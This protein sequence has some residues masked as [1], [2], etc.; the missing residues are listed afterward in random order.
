MSNT[1]DANSKKIAAGICAILL[2][3]LGIHK[4]I[5]G[6]TTQGVI[7]L[8]ATLLTCGIGGVVT[9]V[10]GLAEGIIYLTKSDE[11]FFNTYVA[12]KKNWF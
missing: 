6:Y 3:S 9:W 4:F 2:G 10:I 5:L 7:L 1:S 12:N 11:E 8:L